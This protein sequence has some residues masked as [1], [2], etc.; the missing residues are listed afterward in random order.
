M[1]HLPVHPERSDLQRPAL[2]RGPVV[3]GLICVTLASV[4]GAILTR[5]MADTGKLFDSPALIPTLAI[6]TGLIAVAGWF[7]PAAGP[8]L[9]LAPVVPYLFALYM[10]PPAIGASLGPVAA[11]FLLLGLAIPWWFGFCASIIRKARHKY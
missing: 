10:D 2:P 11:L 4:G 8:Y 1:V 3:T 5:T 9:G 6:I 7:A